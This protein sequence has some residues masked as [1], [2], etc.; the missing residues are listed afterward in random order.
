MSDLR[1][2]GMRAE[3]HVRALSG[4]KSAGS[5]ERGAGGWE[6]GDGESQQ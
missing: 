2:G 5:E 3:T 4:E 6:V 1:F